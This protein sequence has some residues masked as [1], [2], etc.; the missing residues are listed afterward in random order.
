MEF[1]EYLQKGS[2]GED[3]AEL[4]QALRSLGYRVGVDGKF[5]AK[6]EEA[7]MRFQLTY[8]LYDDGVVGEHF[9]EALNDALDGDRPVLATRLI[10]RG[11]RGDD[12]GVLQAI[13]NEMGYDAGEPDGV[14]GGGTHRALVA[15]QEDM[16]LDADGIVG[17][18]TL[19]AIFGV[20][21]EEDEDDE[22]FDS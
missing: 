18:D 21:D 12:V 1:T 8:G 16:G 17:L 10:Q 2:E 14:F 6:T 11:H 9:I 7:V 19:D 4:Q 22:E 15:F 13:L 3:V 20:G 5:G